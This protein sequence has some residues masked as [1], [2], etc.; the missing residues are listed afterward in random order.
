MQW[1]RSGR[2]RENE[3]VSQPGQ[4]V[5]GMLYLGP[6]RNGLPV[7]K[8]PGGPGTPV[9]PQ[10]PTQFPWSG[11]RVDNTDNYTWPAAYSALYYFGC[12]HP[13]NCPEIFSGYD[14]YLEEV[15]AYICCPQCS[16]IQQVMPLAQYQDN[17][18]TPLVVA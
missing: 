9:F 11:A 7:W 10:L 17:Q 3:G 8:Q 6:N 14:P 1:T 18:Q 13:L 5:V 4:L 12:G 16:Y 15:M 2:R